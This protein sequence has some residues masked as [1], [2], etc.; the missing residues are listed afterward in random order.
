MDEVTKLINAT[1]R[2]KIALR[3]RYT[4]ENIEALLIYLEEYL[5]E[6]RDTDNELLYFLNIFLNIILHS[7]IKRYFLTLSIF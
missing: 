5:E 6:N 2:L 1:H 3:H 7:L 4:P